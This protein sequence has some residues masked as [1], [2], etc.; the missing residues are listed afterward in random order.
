VTVT[1]M[2]AVKEVHQRTQ[3]EQNERQCAH[4]MGA[5]LREEEESGHC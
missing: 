3:R 1:A 5:M 2:A 4:Q